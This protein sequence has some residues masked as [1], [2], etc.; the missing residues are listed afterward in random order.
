[1]TLKCINASIAEVTKGWP[2]CFLGVSMFWECLA[3]LFYNQDCVHGGE[4]I[5]SLPTS[6]WQV[7]CMGTYIECGDQRIGGLCYIAVTMCTVGSP[8]SVLSQILH[9]LSYHCPIGSSLWDPCLQQS[10]NRRSIS[11]WYSI[12]QKPQV[13]VLVLF[14]LLAQL[15]LSHTHGVVLFYFHF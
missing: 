4:T 3:L 6:L 9:P 10:E 14:F 13:F 15:T 11:S 5:S 2:C 12:S 1:M 7:I 8:S